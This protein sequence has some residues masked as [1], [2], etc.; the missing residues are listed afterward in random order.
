M[1]NC[2]LQVYN[3]WEKKSSAGWLHHFLLHKGE[4]DLCAYIHSSLLY[5]KCLVFCQVGEKDDAVRELQQC[6]M[7]VFVIREDEDPL[8]P[9][10]DIVI[11][12][13]SVEVLNELP[14]IAHGCALLFGL[15]YAL[16]LSYPGEL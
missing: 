2:L 6:S 15:I 4:T 9:P 16:N 1:S 14:S 3:S 5:N 7:E 8:K 11:I 13:E 12:T 10:R